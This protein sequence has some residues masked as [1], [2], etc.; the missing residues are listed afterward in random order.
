MQIFIKN[1]LMCTVLGTRAVIKKQ[2]QQHNF[3]EFPGGPV[4]RTQHFQCR[5]LGNPDS[6]WC[7]VWRGKKPS[8]F[9]IYS[10][11]NG[12]CVSRNSKMKSRLYLTQ[13]LWSD[14]YVVWTKRQ[15]GMIGKVP[16]TDGAVYAHTAQAPY[17]KGP[18]SLACFMRLMMKQP[19]WHIWSQS[20]FDSGSWSSW[21]CDIFIFK[22]KSLFHITFQ[23]TK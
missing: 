17:A 23:S 13:E 10:W 6:T 3:G 11:I 1:W 18:H 4:V 12:F 14:K 15:R 8:F 16:P 21:S 9:K 7:T 19:H 22:N 2:Q 5:M 20:F